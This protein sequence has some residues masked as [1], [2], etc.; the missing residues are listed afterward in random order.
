MNFFDG[1]GIGVFFGLFNWWDGGIEKCY[2]TTLQSDE[3]LFFFLPI[4]ENCFL[5]VSWLKWEVG[6]FIV[7]LFSRL[8]F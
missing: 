6:W 5:T 7:T 4:F 8:P 3:K 2:V 1:R